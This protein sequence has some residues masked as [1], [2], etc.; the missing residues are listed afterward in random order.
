MEKGTRERNEK[1]TN[2]DLIKKMAEE[3]QGD[4]DAF[5]HAEMLHGRNCE[6][7]IAGNGVALLYALTGI[8]DRFSE[9]ADADFDETIEAIKTMYD[10]Y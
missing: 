5:I 10:E 1:M 7:V 3:H 4:D 8:I 2:H 9:L 6:I